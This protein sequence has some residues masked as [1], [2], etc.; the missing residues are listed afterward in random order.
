MADAK[1]DENRVT[2]TLGASS[3]DGVTPVLVKVSPTHVLQVSDGTTG[4]DFGRTPA[5]RDANRV[6][7]LMGVS[8][9]D[10]ITPVEIYVN[11]STGEILTKST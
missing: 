6:E 3:A 1:R 7:I 11:P 5:V 8:S 10:G 9:A 4:S 2:T